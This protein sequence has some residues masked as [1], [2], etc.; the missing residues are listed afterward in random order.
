M[1]VKPFLIACVFLFPVLNQTKTKTKHNKTKT[2]KNKQ[3][4]TKT[5]TPKSS[6][7]AY[8]NH[9]ADISWEQSISIRNWGKSQRQ[10]DQDQVALNQGEGWKTCII[11][12]GMQPLTQHYFIAR[13]PSKSFQKSILK[14]A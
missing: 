13:R 12:D 3:N 14:Q 6:A 2:T 9:L 4:Q 7:E 8:Q 1:K 11:D 10:S 5:K